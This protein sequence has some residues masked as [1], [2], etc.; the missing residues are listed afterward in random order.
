MYKGTA[1][2]NKCPVLYLVRSRAARVN[3]SEH[4]AHSCVSIHW[5]VHCVLPGS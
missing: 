5:G 4:E 2:K 1:Y 3:F